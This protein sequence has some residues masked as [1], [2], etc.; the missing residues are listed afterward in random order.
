MENLRARTR[1]VAGESSTT[2]T[3]RVMQSHARHTRSRGLQ[4]TCSRMCV[5]CSNPAHGS[6]PTPSP[7]TAAACRDRPGEPRSEA[8]EA[9]DQLIVRRRQLVDMRTMEM[10]REQQATAAHA[11]RRAALEWVWHYGPLECGAAQTA[12]GPDR[13]CSRC[14]EVVPSSFDLCWNCGAEIRA[15]PAPGPSKL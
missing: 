10:N 13:E 9:I 15:P 8:V 4:G 11:L 12:H 7:N 3:L 14:H 1:F 5:V 6:L 2:D